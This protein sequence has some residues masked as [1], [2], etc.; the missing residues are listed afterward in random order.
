MYFVTLITV[1]AERNKEVHDGLKRL[2][3]IEGVVIKSIFCL[4]GRYDAIIIS[5]A[6]EVSTA[7]NLAVEIRK[8]GGVLEAETMLASPLINE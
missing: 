5:D 2:K 3:S 1:I 8:I 7:M 6:S 4:F